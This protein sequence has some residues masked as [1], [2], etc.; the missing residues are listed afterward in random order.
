VLGVGTHIPETTMVLASFSGIR[1]TFTLASSSLHFGVPFIAKSRKST[2]IKT[3][4]AE[5]STNYK[6]NWIDLTNM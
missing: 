5:T 6:Q 4:A 1:L 2:I 3:T